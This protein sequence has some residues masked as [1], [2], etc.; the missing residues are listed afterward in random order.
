MCN[1]IEIAEQMVD[2]FGGRLLY[3][4]K[5]GSHAY[6]LSREDSD[7]DYRGVFVPGANGILGFGYP[8]HREAMDP[9]D[10]QLYSLKKFIMLALKGNPNILEMLWISELPD[11]LV[12]LDHM[13]KPFLQ[14]RHAFLSKRIKNTYGGYARGEL[15]KITSSNTSPNYLKG[16]HA[17]HCYRLVKQALELAKTGHMTVRPEG[18]VHDHLVM[19]QDG[20]DYNS[21]NDS[22]NAMYVMLEELDKPVDDS[23]HFPEEPA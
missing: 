7:E 22:V 16:K 20:G 15:R 19:L 3:L 2:R 6:G 9:F 1:P 14:N 17:M 23:P 4:V 10:M 21:D 13:F 8:E 12:Y 18:G 11:C 5:A